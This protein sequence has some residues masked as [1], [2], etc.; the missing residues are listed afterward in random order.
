MAA[1]DFFVP[2]NEP[3]HHRPIR[4]SPNET[5]AENSSAGLGFACLVG[6]RAVQLA[7]FLCKGQ[8]MK[9]SIKQSF[10]GIRRAF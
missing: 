4:R 2:F 3:K 1:G 6:V 8:R 10:R 7:R 9:C 5:R